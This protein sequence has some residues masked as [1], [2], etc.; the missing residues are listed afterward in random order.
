[1]DIDKEKLPDL[2]VKQA[3]VT[4]LL[5]GVILGGIGGFTIAEIDSKKNIDTASNADNQANTEKSPKE[6]FRKISNDLNLETETVMSCYS[7]SSNS[8][9]IEDRRNAGENLGSF[10]TPTF[11]VGN[12]KNGFVEITGAQPVSRF[13]EAFN[14]VQSNTS[15]NLTS[16]NGIELENEPSKGAENASIKIVEYN[17]FGCPFC[18]EWQG[19]DASGRTPIDKMNIANELETK[20]VD[21]GKVEFISKDY[22]VPQLHP[23]GPKA[24]QAANCVYKHEKE[25]Y[26]KFYNQ[27]F[28]RR[29]KWMK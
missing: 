19:V 4:M 24:H 10:G 18:A 15:G 14:T 27:L 21:T 9:A 23:N 22:P 13:E 12:R 11:F 20:Y 16:L 25:S 7:N 29:D 5:T 8:E 26:W 6:V 28:E 3:A 2:T 1:M 17:E